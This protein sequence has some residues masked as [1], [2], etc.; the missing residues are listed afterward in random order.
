M[1]QRNHQRLPWNWVQATQRAET[2][3]QKTHWGTA[4]LQWPQH[5]RGHPSRLWRLVIQ[6]L[7]WCFCWGARS[8][9]RHPWPGGGRS[10]RNN[11]AGRVVLSR[12]RNKSPTQPPY[13]VIPCSCVP[14]VNEWR[15][16]QRQSWFMQ[17]H[18]RHSMCAL[19]CRS[20]CWLWLKSR[21]TWVDGKTQGKT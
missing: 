19:G 9:R 18:L 7:G 17:L 2:T 4:T 20:W 5:W 21:T 16:L 6:A 10:R 8:K 12:H 14:E 3:P 1:V 13:Q 15:V 11:E